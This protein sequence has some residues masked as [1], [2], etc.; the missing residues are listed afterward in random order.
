MET[1]STNETEAVQSVDFSESGRLNGI[2]RRRR[3]FEEPLVN[4]TSM[5]DVLAVLMFFL[6][7]MFSG[8]GYLTVLPAGLNPPN[9]DVRKILQRNLE[10]SV[11]EDRIM[12]DDELVPDDPAT[13]LEN[14]TVL[15]PG[16]HEILS[17]QAPQGEDVTARIT[18][19]A[20]RSIPFRLLKKVMY[21]ADQA[22]F[23]DLSL[24]VRQV[25]G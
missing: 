2:R 4:L 15:L 24:A 11:L 23:H 14:E 19:L 25:Q 22:G 18:I 5:V 17:A 16:L 20:D 21:T 8:G 9:S 7:T 13:Y 12:V 3:D 10:V 1:K 6:L